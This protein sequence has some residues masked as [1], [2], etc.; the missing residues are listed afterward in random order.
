MNTTNACYG[1]TVFGQNSEP[2]QQDNSKSAYRI[3][4]QY[5]TEKRHQNTNH[6]SLTK[7]TD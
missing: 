7:R 4:L 5:N 1:L 2:Y 3:F 6:C